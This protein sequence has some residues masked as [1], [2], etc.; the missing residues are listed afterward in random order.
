MHL[1][2]HLFEGNGRNVDVSRDGSVP[3]VAAAVH[4]MEVRT[5]LFTPGPALHPAVSLLAELA[6]LVHML[7]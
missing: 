1:L 6:E 4:V 3:R 2:A 5:A 7:T